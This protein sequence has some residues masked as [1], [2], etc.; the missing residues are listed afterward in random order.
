MKPARNC[1]KYSSMRGRGPCCQAGGEA[2]DPR[3]WGS[4]KSGTQGKGLCAPMCTHTCTHSWIQ[5]ELWQ[6]ELGTQLWHLMCLSPQPCP[7]PA[8]AHSAPSY[9]PLCPWFSDARIQALSPWLPV[10]C[11]GHL[12]RVLGRPPQEKA[13]HRI[14]LRRPGFSLC[15]CL[16]IQ[17]RF[18]YYKETQS[19]PR[20]L[21]APTTDDYFRRQWNSENQFIRMFWLQITKHLV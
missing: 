13:Y 18:F 15:F 17:L 9:L 7:G 1:K 20:S 8:E 21:P 4:L 16:H 14:R 3:D 11:P 19:S 12:L 2:G 6:K 10:K 5:Q